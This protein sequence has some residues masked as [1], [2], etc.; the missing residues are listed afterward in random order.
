[1]ASTTTANATDSICEAIALK[2][3]SKTEDFPYALKRGEIIR[4]RSLM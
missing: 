1:M 4:L 3:T 2:A